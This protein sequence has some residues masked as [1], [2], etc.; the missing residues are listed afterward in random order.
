[1]PARARIM[2]NRR[3]ARERRAL[4][5]Q[6]WLRQQRI[7]RS[8]HCSPEQKCGNAGMKECRLPLRQCMK[9]AGMQQEQRAR[10]STYRL[11]MPD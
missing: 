4:A 8:V 7:N 11:C 2:M 5:V 10:G 1:M 6:L 3:Q 9:N